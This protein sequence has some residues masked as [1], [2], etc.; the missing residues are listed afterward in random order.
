[1]ETGA[2]I[3]FREFVMSTPFINSVDDGEGS[4]LDPQT[5]QKFDF[6]APWFTRGFVSH[7]GANGA[8]V[9]S[10][11]IPSAPVSNGLAQFPGDQ[12]FTLIN[13]RYFNADAD[14]VGGYLTFMPSDDITVTESGITWRLPRRLSGTETWPAMD[15][16][17]S[18]W[19]FSME[20][21][22]A[23]YIWRGM[24]VVKLFATDNPNVLTFSGQPLTYHVIEHFLGGYEYD[25]TVP[26]SADTLDLQ[27][28]IV[29][30]SLRRYKYDPVNPLGLMDD[31]LFGQLTNGGSP[32][33]LPVQVLAPGETDFVKLGISATLPDDTVI[34]PTADDIFFAFKSG[35]AI[36]ADDDWIQASWVSGGPPYQATLLVG[37]DNGGLPLA[38]GQYQ[39]WSKLVDFPQT[40]V[41]MIGVL[42]TQ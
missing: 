16:G 8:F 2:S 20:G 6:L 9:N 5:G 3:V 24:L 4:A 36:P 41:E 40:I 1:M 42:Y 39:I 12:S 28:L 33:P 35:G 15:S 21:S 38:K 17:S 23:I 19:A 25:I 34:D 37:P 27:S 26:T 29:P 30:G 7:L 10:D 32:P 31:D 14:P 22:G 13:Q 18:P 11:L